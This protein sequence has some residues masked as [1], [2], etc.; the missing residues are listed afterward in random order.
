[1]NRIAKMTLTSVLLALTLGMVGM[2]SAGA[3][4]KVNDPNYVWNLT[5]NVYPSAPQFWCGNGQVGMYP[6]A[7]HAP[8]GFGTVAAAITFTSWRY[9][10]PGNQWYREFSHSPNPVPDEPKMSPGGW[11]S[12]SGGV[13][14]VQQHGWYYMQVE[15]Q[16]WYYT[17]GNISR[18]FS[19]VDVQPTTSTDYAASY[20][21]Q[22]YGYQVCYA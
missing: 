7:L 6:V 21:S 4:T 18:D 12:T 19:K 8:T 22:I 11:A 9:T 5:G 1:M 3:T 17:N 14:S 2:Q 10:G 20:H 16:W 13:W 15:V